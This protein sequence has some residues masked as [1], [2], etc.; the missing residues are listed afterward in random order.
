[1]KT[2]VGRHTL[3]LSVVSC[4]KLRKPS[5]EE[6]ANIPEE[7]SLRDPESPEDLWP[8]RACKCEYMTHCLALLADTGVWHEAWGKWEKKM[9]CNKD[10]WGDS[11]WGSH[12]YMVTK[13]PQYVQHLCLQTLPKQASES[14]LRKHENLPDYIHKL[15][16][17]QE[18][19]HIPCQI[20]QNDYIK[21]FKENKTG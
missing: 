15:K 4:L 9:T 3:F 17:F 8:S 2:W 1:M 12:S 11:N 20:D 18:T 6:S 5:L 19:R 13:T 10:L 16:L 21:Y 7:E 14:T